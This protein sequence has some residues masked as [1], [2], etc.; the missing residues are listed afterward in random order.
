MQCDGKKFEIEIFR[1]MN[2]PILEGNYLYSY[3]PPISPGAFIPISDLS[4][5]YRAK[6]KN[7]FGA[8]INY[9]PMENIG[10]RLNRIISEHL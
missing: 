4:V 9:F 2:L 3:F 10:I 1:N 5:N 6:S 8:G 7:G